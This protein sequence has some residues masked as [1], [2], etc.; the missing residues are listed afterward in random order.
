MKIKNKKSAYLTREKISGVNPQ[1]VFKEKL[2]LHKVEPKPNLY[3]VE[4]IDKNWY[5][6]KPK[7]GN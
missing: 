4:I 3:K 1:I 6:S 2:N 7:K 5:S